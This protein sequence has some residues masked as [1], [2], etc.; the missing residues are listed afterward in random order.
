MVE[1]QRL[2][3]QLVRE[4]GNTNRPGNNTW[5]PGVNVHLG[6]Q[7]GSVHLVSVS[8]S[9]KLTDL[10]EDLYSKFQNSGGISIDAGY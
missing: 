3:Y 10:N 8:G 5:R 6:C 2:M 4:T 9:K 7:F 1:W